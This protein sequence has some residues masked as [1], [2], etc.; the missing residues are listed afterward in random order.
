MSS[1]KP[2]E[3]SAITKPWEDLDFDEKAKWVKTELQR[4]RSLFVML[5]SQVQDVRTAAKALEKK[6]QEDK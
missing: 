5:S 2:W 3:Y 6:I 4:M 1:K